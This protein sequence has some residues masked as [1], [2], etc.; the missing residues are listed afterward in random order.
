MEPQM[1][2]SLFWFSEII[3]CSVVSPGAPNFSG[4][5]VLPIF[6]LHLF[7]LFLQKLLAETA[8]TAFEEQT[9]FL[10]KI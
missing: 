7:L 5:E 8:L 9:S 2:M 1:R 3:I 6:R 10:R 4:D